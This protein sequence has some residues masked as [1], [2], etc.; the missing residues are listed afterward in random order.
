[1]HTSHIYDLTPS[2]G[3]WMRNGDQRCLMDHYGS[4]GALLLFSPL[5]VR[6]K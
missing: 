2:A 3:V 5:R 4:V 6:I 1:M